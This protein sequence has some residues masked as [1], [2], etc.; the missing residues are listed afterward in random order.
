MISTPP[1]STMNMTYEMMVRRELF[2]GGSNRW[3]RIAELVLD[4]TWRQTC[5]LLILFFINFLCGVYTNICSS[6]CIDAEVTFCT[7][8]GAFCQAVTEEWE[9]ASQNMLE[10]VGQGILGAGLQV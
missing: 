6:K 4:A 10:P 2:E 3:D 5:S 8:V 7:F 9:P 1:A